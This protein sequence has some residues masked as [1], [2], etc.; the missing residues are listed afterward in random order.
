VAQLVG[1]EE[2]PDRDAGALGDVIGAPTRVAA[3]L[4]NMS[5]RFEDRLDRVEGALLAPG[6][7]GF[8]TCLAEASREGREASSE[9]ASNHSE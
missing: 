4:E 6:S 5:S 1:P 9:I 7:T 3:A 2:R 8:S